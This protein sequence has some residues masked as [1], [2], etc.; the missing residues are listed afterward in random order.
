METDKKKNNLVIAL[1]I[2]ICLISIIVMLWALSRQGKSEQLE[3][4]PP[5]FES[6]AVIGTPEVPA[7]L[8]WEELDAQEFKAS[9]CG[10]VKII[11][12][13]ADIWFTNPDCNAVWMKLR[14][15]DNSGN[16]LGETGLIKPDEYI[17]SIQFG[18][19]PDEGEEIILKLMAYEPETYYSAGSVT[20]KTM[21]AGNEAE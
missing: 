10:V 18:T 20:L 2:V 12:G 9:V 1:M 19:V 7:E 13:K 11:A 6:T 4:T 5:P 17:Q 21:V 3:F 8:G 16:I 14:V 15:T